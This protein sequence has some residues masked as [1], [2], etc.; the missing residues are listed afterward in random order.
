[1][2]SLAFLDATHLVAKIISGEISS[3]ALLEHFIDRVEKYNPDINA[4]IYK[5]YDQARA[6][7]RQADAA[8]QRG[9]NWGRLHGL[10]MTV[11]EAFDQVGTPSTWGT[12][13]LKNNI[14][15]LDSVAVQRLQAEGAVIFGKTNVPIYLADFQSYNEIYGTTNNPHD[16]SRVPG[17][18]SGGS[19]AAVAAGLS[20]LEIGSDIG[21]SIRNPAHYCGVFGH[22][23]TFG[24]LPTRGH[25]PPG[26]LTPADIA[27]I[28]PLARS[29]DDLRL[30][31]EIVGGADDLQS[32]GWKLELP[33][34]RQQ[35]LADYRIAVW[36][37]D[38]QAPVEREVSQRVLQVAGL[39]E[40]AGGLVDYQARPKIDAADSHELYSDLLQAAMSVGQSDRAFS[41]NF[42]K[43]QQLAADD[44]SRHARVLRA[45]TMPHRDW[46]I[47]NERR[48]HIRWAW[49]QFFQD[50]DL[51]LMPPCTTVAFPH[52]QNPKLSERTLMVDGEQRPYFDQLFWA[53]LAG[54]A[55]LPA[56]IVPTGLGQQVLPIGVQIVGPEMGDLS[57]I[58]FARMVHAEQ[59]GFVPAQRFS[60]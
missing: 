22:K 30:V 17:G 58:E 11:K 51:V 1:M 57:T 18:S 33:E 41:E 35:S 15:A 44:Q 47:L 14:A 24:I 36:A 43:R 59:G 26:V 53:G 48:S 42:Q 31:M 2:D 34:P 27:V 52:Q 29:A 56:T 16:L 10:P 19:A 25:A 38:V 39:V 7:A 45:S 49:H 20:A 54:V 60:E 9:E 4:I 55:H 12:P 32:P 23:P 50:Y 40:A 37:E 46:Q 28:G 21:G 5:T 8:L 13:S 6:R 3:Q